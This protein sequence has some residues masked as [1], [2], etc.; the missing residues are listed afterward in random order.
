MHF[1]MV[2]ALWSMYTTTKTTGTFNDTANIY[3]RESLQRQVSLAS[4]S[5][6]RWSEVECYYLEN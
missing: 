3:L 4:L 6:R 2:E 5:S 1:K